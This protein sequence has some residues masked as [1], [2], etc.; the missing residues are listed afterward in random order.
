MLIAKSDP[1]P[2]A[3]FFGCFSVPEFKGLIFCFLDQ[4]L[5]ILGEFLYHLSIIFSP[6]CWNPIT[7]FWLAEA[8]FPHMSQHIHG[9]LKPAEHSTCHLTVSTAWKLFSK[10]T[11]PRLQG[12]AA[13]FQVLLVIHVSVIFEVG[14]L[15]M[16]S[17]SQGQKSWGVPSLVVSVCWMFSAAQ[18][19]GFPL[20]SLKL[21]PNSCN[22]LLKNW[23]KGSAFLRMRDFLIHW[24]RSEFQ[25]NS[26]KEKGPWDGYVVLFLW[27]Q[28][29]S[30]LDTRVLSIEVK[31]LKTLPS[32]Q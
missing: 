17:L 10:F 12:W 7:L 3:T 30:D 20:W 25:E 6:L 26:L 9:G 24:M 8:S 27:S 32:W 23:R 5:G 15:I 21:T 2:N 29:F 13:Q 19:A 14:S 4:I 28:E 22:R 1:Y 16:E 18:K 31:F 11:D